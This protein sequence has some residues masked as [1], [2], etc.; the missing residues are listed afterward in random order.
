MTLAQTK[1]QPRSVAVPPRPVRQ[2]WGG[3]HARPTREI[4]LRMIIA[5]IPTAARGSTMSAISRPGYSRTCRAQSAAQDASR[6]GLL[7]ALADDAAADSRRAALAAP[8]APRPSSG[9]IG[10]S[11]Q[12]NPAR[13]L[14]TIVEDISNIIEGDFW[15]LLD[16]GLTVTRKNAAVIS[17][18]HQD[19]CA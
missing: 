6:L 19:T 9:G 1:Q 15:R 14:G 11:Y 18:R 17:A 5:S 3:L 8:R 4:C 7:E 16:L 2:R 10:G 13:L 12:A